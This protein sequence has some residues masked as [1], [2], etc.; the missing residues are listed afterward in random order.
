MDFLDSLKDIKKDMLKE[1]KASIAPKPKPK[2][3]NPNRDEFK[4][5]FKD[6]LEADFSSESIQ[7]RENRL[8]DE[9]EEFIKHAGVK[10]I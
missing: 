7:T 2:K 5:I 1:Q 9:F 4:D 3:P 8:K 6:D 10:K